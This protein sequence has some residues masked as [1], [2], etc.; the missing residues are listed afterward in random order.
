MTYN[1]HLPENEEIMPVKR[2]YYFRAGFKGETIVFDDNMRQIVNSVYIQGLELSHARVYYNILPIEQVPEEVIPDIFEGARKMVIFVSTLGSRID[3]QITDY[4]SGKMVL[5]AALLDAW[6]SEA[7][8]ALNK[9]FDSKLRIQYGEGTRRFSP[10]YGNVNIRENHSIL[11]LLE[12]EEVRA[13]SETGILQPRK[14]TVCMLG[15]FEQ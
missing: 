8:E 3:L 12:I 6:G 10:G 13:N 1:I 14:S 7:V 11:E 15:F 4:L 5:H 2:S 9:S